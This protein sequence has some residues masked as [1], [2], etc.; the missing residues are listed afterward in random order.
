MTHDLEHA[1]TEAALPP[2]P[3]VPGGI[4]LAYDGLTIEV[5]R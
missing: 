3:E 2:H 5:G 4:R 1:A